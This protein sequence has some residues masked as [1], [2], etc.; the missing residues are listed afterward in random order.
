MSSITNG[1][2]LVSIQALP[3]Q[4]PEPNANN[5]IRYVTLA[6]IETYDGIVGWGECIS[7]WPEAALAVK[8]IIDS[9]FAP[10]LMGQDG[11]QAGR[12][13]QKMRGH[14]YW[15]GFGGIVSFAISALDIA[16]WDIAGKTAGLPISAMLGGKLLDKVPACASVILNTLDLGALKEEFA[17]YRERGFQAVK[18]GWGQVPEAGFGTNRIRDMKVARTVRD[19]IGPTLGMALDVSAIAKWSASHAASMAEQLQEVNLTWLEDALHH[20]DHNGYR[21]MKSRVPTALATG[22]RCWTLN[23]YQRL[24]RSKGIDIILVD[25]GRVEGIS[26]MKAIVDDAATQRIR[27]VPHSWSSAINTAAALHVY[28]ASTNGEIFEI[29][30]APSPMQHELVETPIDQKSGWILVS[31][32]PGLGININEEIVKKYL[33]QG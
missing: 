11:T 25:P 30:P 9:G 19:T 14:A 7:Q 27:F 15:H 18:G 26:G 31:D 5:R 1:R 24:V 13:W 22:E 23:D 32:T 3:L 4:Y 6:R 8:T 21:Q 10:I 16:L 17:S 12:L 20:D 28:A 2:K 33:Y 29:K